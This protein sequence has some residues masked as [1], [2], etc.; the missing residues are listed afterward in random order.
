MKRI[1]FFIFLFANAYISLSQVLTRQIPEKTNYLE[2][3][4]IDIPLY[5]SLPTNTVSMPQINIDSIR[6]ER[7]L[8]YDEDMP[9]E[10]G[11]GFDTSFSLSDFTWTKVADG[12]IGCISFHSNNASS[13]NFVFNNFHLPKGAYLCILN[14]EKSLIYGPVYGE[15]I[16]EDG[17]FLTDIIVGNK[18]K[19]IIFE[20]NESQGE[21]RL[22]IS[23]VVHGYDNSMFNGNI[24]NRYLSADCNVPIE[25]H[26]EYSKESRAV[27]LILLEGGT[28]LCSGALIMTTDSLFKPYLLTAYHCISSTADVNHWAIKFLFTETSGI[29]I[30]FNGATYLSG[31]ASSDFA[32]TQLTGDVK[33]IAPYLT[34]LGWDRSGS[35]PSNGAGIHH[36]RGDYM[37]ISIEEDT[38]L[39]SS[40]GG[41]NNH[42]HVNWDEGI[43]QPGSSGS[44]LL[45][46]NKRVVGQVHGLIYQNGHNSSTPPCELNYTDYGKFSYSWNGN[47]TNDTR[48][49]NWL[50]S[51][52]SGS[53]TMNT[54]S[55]LK[56]VG[57]SYINNFENYSISYGNLNIQWRTS[58]SDITVV[59]GQGTNSVTLQNN[60]T[61]CIFTLYADI[62]VSG[63][64]VTIISKEITAG[65]PPMLGMDVLPVHLV[66]S[67]PIN[68][69]LENST[70]NGFII[71]EFNPRNYNFL[72]ATLTNI[73]NL[74]N[75][76]QV[77]HYT[78]L[79]PSASFIN[80][81]A[82]CGSG[83]YQ[84]KVRGING[85]G[86]TL[87]STV[88]IEVGGNGGGFMELLLSYD[89]TT[90]TVSIAM[91][92]ESMAELGNVQLWSSS[93]MVRSYNYTGQRSCRIHVADLRNGIYIVRAEAN[94]KVYI[95]KFLK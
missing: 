13:L 7:A 31:W 55:P 9:Y 59:S 42:W 84:L 27:A 23:K 30:T 67:T 88:I 57:S 82:S 20:P 36:P 43:T 35:V 6:K 3:E 12:R 78:N 38:F 65:I 28:A 1:L 15:M 80:I 70:G 33:N 19:I 89:A 71:E 25:E 93:S 56:I 60:G 8:V 87:W 18:A 41:Y 90:E 77:A 40:W 69:W 4:K 16:P 39:S 47:G 34:W 72:E 32:L 61:C 83:F 66:G 5:M 76:V 11:Y 58:N 73:T 68:G 52:G 81:P 74:S 95:G 50:D 22:T 53:Y 79:I 2:S 14:D 17:Y 64:L 63:S 46:Q 85:C 37:K 45:D 51:I 62:Y 48:L 54:S 44:P 92:E 24:G 86:N 94:G 75:P 21:S 91:P 10:F 49:S 29:S 26:E